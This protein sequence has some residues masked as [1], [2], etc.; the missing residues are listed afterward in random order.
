[1]ADILA[2]P[3]PY[4]APYTISAEGIPARTDLSLAQAL[5]GGYPVSPDQVKDLLDTLHVPGLATH[6]IQQLRETLPR[7]LRAQGFPV[8]DGAFDQ[9]TVQDFLSPETFAQK[10]TAAF[11]D[12]KAATDYSGN[13]SLPID[14]AS[15]NPGTSVGA[16]FTNGAPV[17]A[18]EAKNLYDSLF[19]RRGSDLVLKNGV[20]GA[21]DTLTRAGF[22][23]DLI[24]KVTGSLR[25][26]AGN[27]L[28]PANGSATTK[29]FS[30]PDAFTRLLA[31]LDNQPLTVSTFEDGSSTYTRAFP[32]PD[33]SQSSIATLYHANGR[34]SNTELDIPGVRS[35]SEI[36]AQFDSNVR[37]ATD[38]QTRTADAAPA[39]TPRGSIFNTAPIP[40]A[41]VP[42]QRPRTPGLLTAGIRG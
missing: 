4:Q 10:L 33:F 34:L 13:V 16:R 29:D 27:V 15:Y 7:Q 1:M 41:D 20:D 9:A 40:R 37:N 3:L 24:D 30:S 8:K 18:D 19:E 26:D 17:K 38:P 6:N 11:P 2:Q 36:T 12:R 5:A 35:A 32:P 22:P 31:R 14:P 42:E 25:T 39:V 23:S 28:Q 21:R